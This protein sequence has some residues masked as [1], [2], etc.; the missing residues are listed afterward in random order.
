MNASEVTLAVEGVNEKPYQLNPKT[1]TKIKHDLHDLIL[2]HSRVY[3]LGNSKQEIYLC[4]ESDPI[5]FRKIDT[6]EAERFI[7]L[8]ERYGI[9]LKKLITH[10]DYDSETEFVESKS[11]VGSIDIE[12]TRAYRANQSSKDT[13]VCTVYKKNLYTPENLFLG[14]LLLAIRDVAKDFL[15]K[16]QEE[17]EKAESVPYRQAMQKFQMQLESVD[18]FS[19]FLLNDRFVDKICKYYLKNFESPH[20]IIGLVE[21][22]LLKGK[23]PLRY[24]VLLLFFQ[25][26]KIFDKDQK[27]KQDNFA[28]IL[29]NRLDLKSEDKLYEYFIFYNILEIF[30]NA[31]GKLM[32]KKHGKTHNLY[33]N[34]EYSIEYQDSKRLGWKRKGSPVFRLRDIVIRKRDKIL[35]V[36][37]AKFMPLRKEV[38]EIENQMLI[39]LDYG[40]SKSDLAIVLFCGTG[41]EKV[42]YNNDRSKKMIFESCHPDDPDKV[43]QWMQKKLI[44]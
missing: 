29:V 1:L 33:K 21:N 22:R 35:A 5:Q 23:I 38:T 42:Y 34:S 14:A 44:V 3:D 26:W 8:V 2:R 7:G 41:D 25:V 39:Y 10:L 31:T 27:E 30:A 20:Q 18:K 4:D 9:Y 40:E 32:Q 36:V 19:G 13:V 11:I 28:K 16:I 12:R 24:K 6:S 17:K 43:L 15:G 37:D